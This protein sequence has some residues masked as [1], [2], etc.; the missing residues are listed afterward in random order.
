MAQYIYTN[1]LAAV[2]AA[3]KFEAQG[4]VVVMSSATVEDLWGIEQDDQVLLVEVLEPGEV[5]HVA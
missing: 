1:P 2:K 3:A 4:F 5:R